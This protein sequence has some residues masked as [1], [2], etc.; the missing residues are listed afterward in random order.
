MINEIIPSI[1]LAIKFAVILGLLVYA[2][3]ALILVRQEQLMTDV[4]EEGFESVLKILVIVHLVA[5]VGIIFL[6][7]ILL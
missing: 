7:F 6:A 4:L 2:G 5:S 1:L 3:F